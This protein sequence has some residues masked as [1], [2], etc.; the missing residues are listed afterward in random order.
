MRIASFLGLAATACVLWVSQAHAQRVQFPTKLP[1]NSATAPSGWGSSYPVAQYPATGGY[2]APPASASPY[3][4][5]T[6]AAPPVAS[7]ASPPPGATYGV[8]PAYQAPNYAAPGYS[9]PPGV[10]PGY[11][12]SGPTATFQ[13]TITAPPAVGWDPYATPGVQAPAL[14][15]ADPYL[16]GAPHWPCPPGGG[17]MQTMQRFMDQF[18]VDYTWMP[19]NGPEELGM[20]EA[21]LSVTSVTDIL[22]EPAF[23]QVPGLAHRPTHQAWARKMRMYS[24][25]SF[26]HS[27]DKLFAPSVFKEAHPEFYPLKHPDDEKRYV[28]ANDD[29]YYWQPCFTAPGIV[30]AAAKRIIESMNHQTGHRTYSFGVN[31]SNDY[32]QCENCRKEYIEGEKFLGMA[33][34]T[35]CYMRWCNAVAEKVLQVHPDAWF[36]LIAY[37]HVGAPPVNVQVHPR[38]IP[39][40]TY[41]TMQLIDPERRERHETLLQAWQSKCTYIG[42][43][44]YTY[45]DH[46]VPPR[47]YIHLWADYVRWARDHNVRAWYAE[48]YPF[49]GEAPKYYA[50]AK[51][52]WDPDRDVDEILDEWYTLSFGKAAPPMIAYFNH[53]EDY[54][55]RRV[56]ETGH[57]AALENSQYCIGNRGFLEA[58]TQ[59]DIQIGDGYIKQAL[60]LAVK[61]ML[62]RNAL[63]RQMLRK[64]KVVRGSEHPHQAQ[65]PIALEF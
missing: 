37:S 9:Y 61:G 39:F 47:V 59:E 38:I 11:A 29:D 51:L 43:Y 55:T 4:G 45:G 25:L 56:R 31:D 46:H 21:D 15:P 1:L 63:G 44:D 16:P 60:E 6:Y 52:W 26:H 33:S 48:T 10:A 14:L 58:L 62:P 24:V 40:M 50:M 36:G 28:P 2:A 27:L 54:W 34:Y 65:Q 32:C 57:F 18:G 42:R 17:Y 64:L 35:D 49:F 23:M 19:G 5:S 8:N 7:P 53:W 22:D 41:D 20:H 13:G 12:P 3:P 30:D